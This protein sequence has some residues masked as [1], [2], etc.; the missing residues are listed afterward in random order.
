MFFYLKKC[1]RTRLF[2]LEE[3]DADAHFI[4]EEKT[5]LNQKTHW[6]FI[7]EYLTDPW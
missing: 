7:L 3:Y 6:N 4:D 2:E 5:R 1:V